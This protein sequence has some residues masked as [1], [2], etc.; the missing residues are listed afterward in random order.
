MNKY[1]SEGNRNGIPSDVQDPTAWDNGKLKESYILGKLDES[2][3]TKRWYVT[4]GLYE[5]INPSRTDKI[6]ET[7]ASGTTRTLANGVI[8]FEARIW[9]AP[10]AWSS[11]LNAG[12]CNE[13]ATFTVDLE[14]TLVGESSVDKLWFYPL[15]I[16]K[17]TLN[18][19]Y[20]DATDSAGQYTLITYQLDKVADEGRFIPLSSSQIEVNILQALS[21]IDIVLIKGGTT[22]ATDLF[23]LAES[24]IYG[25]F[26]SYEALVGA[27]TATDWTVLDGVT[28]VV[29]STSAED[30]SAGDYNY[31]LTIPS[32]PA[33]AL[34]VS[35]QKTR[36]S[37]D[38]FGFISNTITITT[39]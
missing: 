29:V 6:Q 38:E 18:A 33:T 34:T 21:L 1:D 30:Q 5:E 28:P 10:Q 20:F 13:M 23:V 22:T 14:G 39:P 24:D 7:A 19:E 3:P 11:N 31:N 32:T 27:T 2:D 25:T 12:S 15:S 35:Y 4:P 36:T 26:N 37:V 8:Q 9:D 16:E 17:D